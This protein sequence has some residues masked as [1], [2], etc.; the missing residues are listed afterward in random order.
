MDATF[1]LRLFARVVELKSFS[2]AADEFG[3]S[4]ALVSKKMTQL[5]NQLSSQLINRSTRSINT[6]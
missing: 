2:A 5:E 6:T 4:R 1:D 3:V